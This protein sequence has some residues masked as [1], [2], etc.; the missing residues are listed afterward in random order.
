MCYNRSK[1]V[2]LGVSNKT[3]QLRERE[4]IQP[5]VVVT[6]F[7]F[8]EA[9]S[10]GGPRIEGHPGRGR[11]GEEGGEAQSDPRAGLLGW[12]VTITQTC[13]YEI[14]QIQGVHCTRQLLHIICMNR[15]HRQHKH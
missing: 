3:S 14:L 6:W 12:E 13:V 15:G 4:S 10:H 1:G 7:G 5:N 8:G 2:F 11:E 9:S